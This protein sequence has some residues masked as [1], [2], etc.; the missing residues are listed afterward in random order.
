MYLGK[1]SGLI[2]YFNYRKVEGQRN[3]VGVRMS[4]NKLMAHLQTGHLS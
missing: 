3:S 1:V 4:Q 2:P